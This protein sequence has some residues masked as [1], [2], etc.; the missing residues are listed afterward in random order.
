[1]YTSMVGPGSISEVGCVGL[2]R[3]STGWVINS[4]VQYLP[5]GK[6]D[7]R[8]V[9]REVT[10]DVP[11]HGDGTRQTLDIHYLT[12]TKKYP[13]HVDEKTQRG[14]KRGRVPRGSLAGRTTLI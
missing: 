11:S 3:E 7:N 2:E 12:K 13:R 10:R 4:N 6:K 5:R 14:L 9:T 1:M 8:N